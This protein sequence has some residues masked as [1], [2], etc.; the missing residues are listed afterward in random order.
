M[1]QRFGSYRETEGTKRVIPFPLIL[2]L[3]LVLVLVL[4]L[5]SN[6]HRI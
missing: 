3:I 2:I 1:C 5:E 6:L 4:V